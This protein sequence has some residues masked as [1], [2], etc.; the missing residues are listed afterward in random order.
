MSKSSFMG[1]LAILIIT[2]IGVSIYYGVSGV[3]NM[4]T[5]KDTDDDSTITVP[6][7]SDG[8][9]TNDMDVNLDSYTFT[10]EYGDDTKEVTI[11]AIKC[12]RLSGFSG[13]PSNVFYIDGDYKLHYLE[14]ANL[15]DKV[16]ATNIVDFKVVDDGIIA[17]YEKTYSKVEDSNFVTYNRKD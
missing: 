13:A 17:Y 16:L 4:S 6:E 1:F 9:E 12:D 3:K 5:P 14:L 7:Q 8:E 11:K 10:N 15:E 2:I